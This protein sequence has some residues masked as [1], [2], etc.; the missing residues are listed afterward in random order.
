[1]DS[2]CNIETKPKSIKDFFRSWSFWRPFLGV[3]A[4]GTAGFLYYHFI[5]CNSGSCV[6]TSNP[7]GSIITGTLLG[8]Y[9]TSSPC[10]RSRS[11]AREKVV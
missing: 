11:C 10:L 5:G 2:N 3:L 8:L 7:F 6:I 1:M 9:I 4:G